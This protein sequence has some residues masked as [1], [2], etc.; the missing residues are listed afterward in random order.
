MN[1]NGNDEAKAPLVY[2]PVRLRKDQITRL[3][4]Q[5][6]RRGFESLAPIT[7]LAVE[8]GLDALEREQI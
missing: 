1:G 2:Q 4:E 8:K 7:R 6:K 5:Q 3:E